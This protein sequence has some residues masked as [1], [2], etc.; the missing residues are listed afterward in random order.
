MIEKINFEIEE[1]KSIK[2]T[3]KD[4]FY[5]GNLELLQREKIS[6]VGSRKLNPYAKEFTYLLAS[7]LSQIGICIVSGGA[8]GADAIAHNG[9]GIANTIMVAGTGLDKR[10][11]AINE[12]LIQGIEKSGLV[13]SQFEPGVPSQ[14]Y[15]FPLRNELIVALGKVLIVT[16]ADIK[17]GSMRSVEYALKMGKE[18]YVLPHRLGES[19]G[20]NELLK[21]ALAK[22]IYDIDAFVSSFKKEESTLTCKDEI[23]EFIKEN[24][25][26]SLALHKYKEKIYEYELNG[27]IMIKNGSISIV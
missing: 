23:L 21:Q 7:K 22:P 24:P 9:A 20:T 1:F 15:N 19:N 2:N 17:S 3:P 14:I 6:I 16:Y 10:Y 26:L 25:S 8:I 5:I 13:L 4:I 18:I 27:K 12:K 11:P